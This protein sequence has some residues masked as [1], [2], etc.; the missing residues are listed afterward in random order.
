MFHQVLVP[1]TEQ[2]SLRFLWREEDSDKISEFKLKVHLF[3][4]KDSPCCAN[5]AL[6]KCAET[7]CNQ[8]I[9]RAILNDFYML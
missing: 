7:Q 1:E 2:D 3:G 6:R 4:K 8:E 9:A 5:W